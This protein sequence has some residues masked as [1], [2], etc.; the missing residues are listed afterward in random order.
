MS[1]IP[2]SMREG[3]G[4][5]LSGG[6]ASITLHEDDGAL[7]ALIERA[8]ETITERNAVGNGANEALLDEV[9]EKGGDRGDTWRNL[10]AELDDADGVLHGTYSEL[11]RALKVAVD[12]RA[13]Q[14]AE[15][16][17]FLQSREWRDALDQRYGG[18]V[19][20]G[21]LLESFAQWHEQLKENPRDAADAIAATYLAQSQYALPDG[22]GRSGR[23]GPSGEAKSESPKRTLNVILDDAIDRHHGKGDG[24]GAAFAA[25]APHRAALKAMFP[26]ITYA[27]ACRRVV[28][29]DGD[30]HRDP[31]GTAARL[32]AAYGMSV[33]PSQQAATAQREA[34]AGDAQDMIAATA[35]HLPGLS[36]IEDD[37]VAVL[38]SPEFLH[39]PDMQQNLLRAYRI[40]QTARRD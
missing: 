4:Q 33:M 7:D 23:N 24:E 31:I 36:D 6:D 20:I 2:L 28:K 22:N 5:T 16:A 1:T 19:A 8:T 35:E 14:E 17:D 25:S 27:E 30:L 34:L 9:D 12:Q 18:R 39:G 32:G 37:V 40:A 11:D 38:Q 21:D 29:L 3:H 15:S 10:K 26:G 13:E